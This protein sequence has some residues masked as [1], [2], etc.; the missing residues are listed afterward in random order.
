MDSSD[1]VLYIFGYVLAFI[2]GVFITRAVFSIPKLIKLQEAQLEILTEIA[3]KQGVKPEVL[4]MIHSSNELRTR[5]QTN[6][7]IRADIE[8]SRSG[9]DEALSQPK[10]K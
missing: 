5:A 2:V 3:K 6:E 9:A 8:R 1:V 10:E 7:E 4:L